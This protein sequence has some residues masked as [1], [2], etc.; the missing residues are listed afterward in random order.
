MQGQNDPEY[1]SIIKA[2]AAITFLAT[3]HRGTNLAEILNRI[4]RSTVV[5]NSKQYISDLAKNSFTLQKLNEQFRHVAPRLDI[6]SFYETRST[7]IGLKGARVVSI[8]RQE[9]LRVCADFSKMILEKES[10]V[11][12]YPGETSNA[13]DADHHNVC[14]YDSPRDPNYILVKNALNS[15]VSKIIST[16]TSTKPHLSN[17]RQSHDLKS[18]L[19]ITELP[20][21]D[22]IFFRDQWAQGTND[23]LLQDEGYLQWVNA[24]DSKPFLLWL[25]G[26]AATGKSVMSSFIINSLVEQGIPCQ[27]FFIRFGDLKKRTLSLLL[28]SI[29]YQIARTVPA[30]LESILQLEDEAIDFETADSRTIWERIFKSILFNMPDVLPLYWVIDGLDEADDPRAL[31]RFL[32]DVSLSFIPIR[33]LLVGRKTSEIEA[34][35]QKIPKSL[36][37]SSLNIEGHLEDLH[38]Y[39]RQELSISW[40]AEVRESVVERILRGA[41]N[42]FLVSIENLSFCHQTVL[43]RQWVRLAVERLNLC[44]TQADIEIALEQLPVG[45]EA[46]YDRMAFSIAQNPSATDR[47]SASTI[48]ECVTCSLRV[49]TIGEL[50]QALNED[51]S[52]MLDFQ[53][54]IVDL[55]G[56]FVV[57]D[58]GGN[59]AM[60]HQTAREYLLSGNS[61][62]SFCV[63]KNAAHKH[64]FLS[65]MRCVMTIGLRAKVKGNQK[66][67]F[68]DYAVSS[69]STHLTS[70]AL[71]CDQT[72]EVLNKFLNGNWV[73]T[74]IQILATSGQLRVLIQT[75]KHLS[76]YSAKQ[77]GN[78]AAWNGDSHYIM[79]QEVIKSWAVDLVK[80]VGKFGTILRRNP[81]SIYK[82]IPPFCPQSSAIFQQFGK[83]KDKSILVSGLSK[84]KWDDSL[85]RMSFG[86][87]TYARSILVA[88]AHIAILVS[89]GSVVL[90]DSSIFQ[91]VTASPITHGE[92]VYRMELNS[93][94]TLLAT[95]GYLTIKIWEVS[96]GKCKL[97][98]QNIK[99]RPRPLAMLLAN[100][101]NKLLVGT[102]DRRVRSL[103]LN[104]TT[105]TWQLVAELE[106]PELEGHFLNAS[107][108]MALNKDG[109]LIAVAYRGHPLSAWE[110]DGPV[111]IGHCWRK[112]EEIARGEVIEAVW[113]PHYPEVLGLY[114]EGVVFK[115][116]PYEDE[117]DELA[118]GASRLAISRDGNLFATGDVRGITKV[119]TTSDLC[120]IY[121][122]ASEDTV[123]GLAIS[124]DLRRF[125]DIRGSY[126][127]AWEPNA[128]MKFAE[129]RGQE[130]ESRSETASLTPSS[131]ASESGS[132]RVDSITTLA[133]SPTGRLYCCG[134]E[135]GIAH[136]HDTQRGKLADIYVSKGFLSIEQMSWS[137]D[138]RYLC[139]SDSSKKVIVMS[140]TRSASKSDALVETKAEI[141]L[142][143]DTNGPILQLLF[144]PDSSQLLVRSSSTICI[145]SLMSS[146]ITQ[147]L[148]LNTAESK[149][150]IHPHDPAL[151]IRV[152]P[153]AI[154]ILDWNLVERQTY[155]LEY[156]QYQTLPLNPENSQDQNSQDQISQD[157]ISQD[158]NTVDRVLITQDKK[159]VLVQIS[160]LKQKSKEKMFLYFE[161]PSFSTAAAAPPGIDQDKDPI[162]IKSH[163]L[164]RNISSQIA[165]PL[166]FLS[167]DNLI[168]LSKNFSVCSWR[169]PF[170]SGLAP[171]PLPTARST[172]AATAR[173]NATDHHHH[174]NNDTDNNTK[175][176]VKP[177][178]W[179]PGDW[180]S[181]D[182]LALCTI[183]GMERSF[184]CPR[185]GEVA[186]VRSAALN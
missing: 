126:G 71:E 10:S 109:S 43:I 142:K 184:L 1:E 12:G 11:L 162:A 158:Q 21:V 137:K 182:C 152:G 20:D 96:T 15:L 31:I 134:T 75:S 108:Y 89:S 131:S 2:V 18:L 70:T 122:L 102:D 73:L 36:N 178:F 87:G 66:P 56:G 92:R 165:H 110:I 121:Q 132:W 175:D 85:A 86:F 168:F 97:S 136:L 13:L 135:K 161:I 35:F 179:L 42:N 93:T 25:N 127:N 105:P 26:G 41:Q 95:Y 74:W 69:W 149:L 58:N 82:L 98:V 34:V 185:N 52:T 80:I 72:V 29:A 181:R 166:S 76:R 120:L 144:H 145:I 153:N 44:H 106:E 103:N 101:S 170:R 38:C 84:E 99:S 117:T 169:L 91:E 83:M 119:Y 174:N 28:R 104:E 49:L 65:C 46:L 141:P 163:F 22:Y 9:P 33:V 140:I 129:Q 53:R 48:L 32:S 27:Y 139:F 51:A 146:S 172:S 157:Q 64:L 173:S 114:I 61:D 77:R 148:E 151:I 6:V 180:I 39:V 138:G 155:K 37:S 107:S 3:P 88:G 154:H 68:L 16:S 156:P 94:G 19:A 123:L 147:S 118:T 113:H 90:Y 100:N 112:R 47:V 177:L 8:C 17:R 7:S 128:L 62:R 79:K 23:W 186:V 171:S 133:T 5:S 63:D 124:P 125:Y 45:M 4:L 176:D 167:R 30:F 115:W 81:E 164:P 111:H 57:I 54:S 59:V 130:I 160:P 116:R 183:W 50:S 24:R 159:H 78:V 67:E 40:P 55:C 60:I 150:I 14:K 143:N